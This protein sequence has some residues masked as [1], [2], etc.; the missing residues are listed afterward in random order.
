MEDSGLPIRVF[1]LLP[2]MVDTAMTEG[3]GKGKIPPEQVAAALLAGI[4]KDHAEIRVGKVRM[5]APVSRFFPRLA[6]RIL[7]D[8]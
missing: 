6:E 3:R 8:A 7:R 4:R 5:L 1:E 2:P